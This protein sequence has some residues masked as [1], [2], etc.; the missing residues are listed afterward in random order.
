MK[1]LRHRLLN[2]NALLVFECA[3]RLTSFTRAA[4]ELGISQPAVTRHVR[5]LEEAL[6]RPLFRRRHNRLALTEPGERLWLS[7]SHGFHDIAETLEAIRQTD[8][9]PRVVVASHSGFAQQW[10]MP[11]FSALCAELRDFDVRL[12]VSDRETELDRGGY[13]FAIRIGGRRA[14]GGPLAHALADEYVFPIASPAFLAANPHY[15]DASPAD[16][17][18]APLL[19]MDEGDQAWMTWSG[20]FRANGVAGRVPRPEVLYTNYPLVLQ[21]VM[22]GRGIALAWRPLT[23][24]PVGQG[25]LVPVG[26]AVHNPETGYYL[27]WRGDGP[28][29]ERAPSLCAWFDVEIAATATPG[30][31]PAAA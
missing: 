11:R 27:T 15:R 28:A 8:S 3:A 30:R 10:L 21:E 24:L 13:D 22:A 4:E 29:A 7:V 31:D 20:W 1:A 14:R 19:H 6:G 12:M 23:D 17:L 25:A 5:G 26:P 9:R 2:A 18:H 16:L